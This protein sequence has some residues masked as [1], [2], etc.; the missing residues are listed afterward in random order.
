M[1]NVKE[2]NLGYENYSSVIQWLNEIGAVE[3]DFLMRQPGLLVVFARYSAIV[4]RVQRN[5]ETVKKVT[6]KKGKA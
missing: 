6:G 1:W 2:F 4:P 3:A 5:A